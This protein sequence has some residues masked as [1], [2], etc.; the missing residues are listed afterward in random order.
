MKMETTRSSEASVH[1]ISK[2]RHFSGDGIL[3]CYFVVSETVSLTGRSVMDI[4]AC[5][6]PLDNFC[7]KH[8]NLINIEKCSIFLSEFN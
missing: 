3:H 4:N 5:L 1:I 7:S 8:F 6:I 2:R